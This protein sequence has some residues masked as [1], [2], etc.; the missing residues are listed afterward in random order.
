MTD[1]S[2][3]KI[4]HIVLGWWKGLQPETKQNGR[5]GGNPRRAGKAAAR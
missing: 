5:R 1:E 4:D 2:E 3:P